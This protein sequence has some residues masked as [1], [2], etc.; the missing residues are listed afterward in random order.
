MKKKINFYKIG[1]GTVPVYMF[2]IVLFFHWVFTTNYGL[3]KFYLVSV[4]IFDCGISR[5]FFYIVTQHYNV[6]V[7]NTVVVV[8]HYNVVVVNTQ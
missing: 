4:Y 5:V 3:I 7:Y 1:V 2:N 6:V 8:V